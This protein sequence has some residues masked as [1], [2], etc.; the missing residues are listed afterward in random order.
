MRIKASWL[1]SG[2]EE[3]STGW[4]K[5]KKGGKTNAHDGC[6][7]RYGFICNTNKTQWDNESVNDLFAAN[8][9]V[10]F[11]SSQSHTPLDDGRRLTSLFRTKVEW[12]IFFLPF[13]RWCGDATRHTEDCTNYEVWISRLLVLPVDVSGCVALFAMPKADAMCATMFCDERVCFVA[14]FGHRLLNY[15]NEFITFECR[16]QWWSWEVLMPRPRQSPPYPVHLKYHFISCSSNG[17]NGLNVNELRLKSHP[18]HHNY[19]NRSG[20][21]RSARRIKDNGLRQ[22]VN[23]NDEE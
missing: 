9:N 15:I 17:T 1:S 11:S 2:T 14:L 6:R 8:F 7:P 19:V 4:R 12:K 23:E 20:F 18:V 16:L 5:K 21:C 22:C 10:P 13:C 3:S